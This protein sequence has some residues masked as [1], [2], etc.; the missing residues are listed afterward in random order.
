MQL[1]MPNQI[2]ALVSIHVRPSLVNMIK[3]SQL[4]GVKM[5]D[6]VDPCVK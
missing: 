6:E 2:A 1:Q 5:A 3:T 4:G